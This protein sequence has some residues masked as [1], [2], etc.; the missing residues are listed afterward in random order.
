M[1]REQRQTGN[2]RAAK[3]SKMDAV[4]P[5]AAA[6]APPRAVPLG[7]VSP[8]HQ[9]ALQQS[10]AE[11]LWIDRKPGDEETLVLVWDGDART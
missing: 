8:T 3:P 7:P 10:A 1:R 11:E 9:E 4:Y 5:P 6:A 2:T